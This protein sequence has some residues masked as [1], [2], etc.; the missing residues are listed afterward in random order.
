[1]RAAPVDA[2]AP[3]LACAGLV[4]VF[5]SGTR[6]LDALDLAVPEGAFFGLL[7]PNGA[8]KTTL[9][10]TITGLTRPDAGTVS[11][12]GIDAHGGLGA[13]ALDRFVSVRDLLQL[14]GRYFG[15][16]RASARVMP[17]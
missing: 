12:F 7:G 11:V 3:A 8:G 16:T 13:L 10:R 5:P 14:H 2:A 15:M 1:V 9:I 4:K 17:K 6:A